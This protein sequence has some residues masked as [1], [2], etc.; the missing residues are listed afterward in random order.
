[1]TL[2]IVRNFLLLFLF[3]RNFMIMKYLSFL[4]TVVS[5]AVSI[6]NGIDTCSV[7]QST[8]DCR[9][10]CTDKD[11]TCPVMNCGGKL[12]HETC[13]Q[14][15]V[16]KACGSLECGNNVNTTCTQDCLLCSKETN[17]TCSSKTCM[18]TCQGEDCVMECTD[19]VKVC[20]QVCSEGSTCTLICGIDTKC[21]SLCANATCVYKGKRP[22]VSTMA[23]TMASTMTPTV[24]P[25]A[26]CNN[27]RCTKSCTTDC[28]NT[29]L[30]CND[31]KLC[32]LECKNGG[33]TMTCDK[34]VTTCNQVCHGNIPCDH[35]CKSKNC[36]ITRATCSLAANNFHSHGIIFL[37]IAAISFFLLT[38]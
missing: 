27:E 15:C 35:F 11:N 33:C 34:T 37:F 26:N 18:Q 12:A 38:N 8:G 14:I 32:N 24:I 6:C 29:V 25:L 9:Q 36:N 16:K 31:T 19:E 3:I 10:S 5:L 22:M 2:Y 20:K 13:H 21:E 28:R 30:S 23:S 7:Q 17:M 4:L 1:M